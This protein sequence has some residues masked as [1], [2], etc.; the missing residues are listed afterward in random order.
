[1]S[2]QSQSPKVTCCMIPFTYN[3]LE[4]WHLQKQQ[5][6]GDQGPGGSSAQRAAGMAVRVPG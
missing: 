1:M 6:H 4:M 3:F 2:E 5:I